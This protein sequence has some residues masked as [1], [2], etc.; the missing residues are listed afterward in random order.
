MLRYG[1]MM[2]TSILSENTIYV[3][4]NGNEMK[5]YIYTHTHNHKVYCIID[6][7]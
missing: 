4:L 3:A 6:K 7:F 1:S 2:P 5:L